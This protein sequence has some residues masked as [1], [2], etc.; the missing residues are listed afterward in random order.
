VPG[1]PDESGDRSR[2]DS[3]TDSN[4]A[5]DTHTGDTDT[6]DT[7]A[8]RACTDIPWKQVEFGMDVA[9][10]LHLDGC[11]ECWGDPRGSI[12]SGIPDVSAA[13]L[14]VYY[15][16]DHDLVAED[17][18]EGC[19]IDSNRR[20]TCWAGED[21]RAIATT[22][23]PVADVA[24]GAYQAFA[25]LLADGEMVVQSSREPYPPIANVS[26]PLIFGYLDVAAT[27]NGRLM[28][29]RTG[30]P[31]LEETD[32]G[33]VELWSYYGECGGSLCGISRDGSGAMY[34]SGAW[35][36]IFPAGSGW[37]AFWSHDH[38][39]LV[40]DA[41]GLVY[42]YDDTTGI[43]STTPWFSEPVVSVAAVDETSCGITADGW[44]ECTGDMK[45]R[46]PPPGSYVLP[47]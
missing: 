1:Q 41:A 25:V 24:F 4:G 22:T 44:L 10:G 5:A 16:Y 29:W 19:V 37:V 43:A 7:A 30:R 3:G 34:Y 46:F 18:P 27:Q 20:I 38:L 14:A 32:L 17:W 39:Y 47:R 21:Y 11:V 23:E 42:E 13:D 31:S 36:E 33:P 8:E 6:G 26:P 12:L 28:N 15:D 35:H 40:Q 2:A 9:C 45:D